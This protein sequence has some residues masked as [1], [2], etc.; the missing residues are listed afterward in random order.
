MLGTHYVPSSRF[1]IEQLSSDRFPISDG[2][3]HIS[4][5]ENRA[6]YLLSLAQK[7]CILS[8]LVDGYFIIIVDDRNVCSLLKR[9]KIIIEY[10]PQFREP[11]YQKSY[12]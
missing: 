4:I 7:D 1:C 5:S 12:Q 6:F 8:E 9:A 10:P 2:V 3:F 11:N